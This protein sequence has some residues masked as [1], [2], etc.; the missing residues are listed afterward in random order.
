M[1][2]KLASEIEARYKEN[3]KERDEILK[4]LPTKKVIKKTEKK[5]EVNVEEK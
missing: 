2:G 5:M 3:L 4:A 1:T